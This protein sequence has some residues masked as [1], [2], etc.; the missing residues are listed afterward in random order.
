MTSFKE[1][2][3]YL[4]EELR[5]KA[6]EKETQRRFEHEAK[7]ARYTEVQNTFCSPLE[8]TLKSLGVDS[9]LKEVQ[10]EWKT[11]TITSTRFSLAGVETRLHDEWEELDEEEPD[12]SH[13]GWE[14]R[15]RTKQSYIGISAVWNFSLP[16]MVP[17]SSNRETT[18]AYRNLE[19]LVELEKTWQGERKVIIFGIS[20]QNPYVGLDHPYNSES[21]T[22]RGIGSP[23]RA[24]ALNTDPNDP[25]VRTIIERFLL[26]DCLKRKNEMPYQTKARVEANNARLR[27]KYAPKN[28]PRFW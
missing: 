17:Y 25:Q 15:S 26:E 28:K 1:K 9:L 3:R 24:I 4:E 11:G 5:G 12:E 18:P 2:L 8:E 7:A 10:G 21:P 13:W 19:E 23:E 27:K 22:F 20:D 6:I 16:K 14:L